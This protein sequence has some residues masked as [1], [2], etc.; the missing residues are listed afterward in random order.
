MSVTNSSA[1]ASANWAAVAGAGS[2]IST[3]TPILCHDWTT[4]E[5]FSALG[6]NESAGATIRELKN[7]G[8]ALMTADH[9]AKPSHQSR[10][11]SAG[12]CT[13]SV[14]QAA[15]EPESLSGGI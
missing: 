14:E 4:C 7:I 5:G 6:E 13:R 15:K 2:R 11:Y 9:A 12:A 8:S 3:G 10:F 1:C